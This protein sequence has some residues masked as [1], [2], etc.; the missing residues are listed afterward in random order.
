MLRNSVFSCFVFYAVLLVL[1]M[2]MLAFITGQLRLRKKAFA[3]PEDAMRHGGPQF[4]RLDP[5]VERCRRAHR[6]DMENIFPFLFLG[7]IYSM[8]GPSLGVARLHFLVFTACRMLH[9]V[10]YLAALP[11]PT[12]SLAY[13]LAQVPCVSMALQILAAVATYA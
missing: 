3:N 11:A 6:N 2:Y 4:H 9:S 13:V 8:T 12:R 1:K 10:A 7:A 5:D